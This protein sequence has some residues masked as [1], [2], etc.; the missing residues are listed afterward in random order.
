MHGLVCRALVERG[1][2]WRSMALFVRCLDATNRYSDSG[3][4]RTFL[5]LEGTRS[6]SQV[7]LVSFSRGLGLSSIG[8][9]H[10]FCFEINRDGISVLAAL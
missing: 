7:V 1:A 4:K 2:L 5:Q 10:S 9:G 6:A 8:W 3:V